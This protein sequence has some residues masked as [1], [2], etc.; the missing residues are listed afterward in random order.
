MLTIFE[1]VAIIDYPP[2]LVELVNGVSTGYIVPMLDGGQPASWEIYPDLPEG[3]ELVNGL[4]VGVPETNLSETVFT[5]WANNTGGSAQAN[6]TLTINQPFFI[7]RYPET[8]IVLDVNESIGPL[9]PLF[10]FEENDK[11]VWTISPELPE[12]MTFT[13]GT[14]TGVGLFPQNL[15]MYTVQVTGEMVPVTFTLMIEIIGVEFAAGIPSLRNETVTEPYVVPEPE[16]KPTF[17]F[18]A[19]WMC[20]IIVFLLLL[21]AMIVGTRIL[22]EGEQPELVQAETDEEDDNS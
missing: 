5:V 7:A 16:P 12:G 4:I 9:A 8:I 14:I 3:M 21:V 1:P 22:K 20:P 13:N 18:D 11:P 19:Y 17:D 15:T 2:V 6:F 10:Y